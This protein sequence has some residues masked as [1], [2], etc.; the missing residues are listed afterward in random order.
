MQLKTIKEKNKKPSH[1]I[2][3]PIPLPLYLDPLKPTKTVILATEISASWERFPSAHA[4]RETCVL[5]ETSTCIPFQSEGSSSPRHSS[6]NTQGD[7]SRLYL[8]DTKWNQQIVSAECYPLGQKDTSISVGIF[9]LFISPFLSYPSLLYIED[10]DKSQSDH[11]EGHEPHLE[12]SNGQMEKAVSHL[13]ARVCR[14]PGRIV[15]RS[16]V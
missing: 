15:A 13:T 7:K 9:P 14:Y 16:S 12:G 11:Q 10:K 2:I 5:Q 1:D 3:Q 4:K 6:T 8:D